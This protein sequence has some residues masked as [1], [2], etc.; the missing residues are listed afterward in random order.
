MIRLK[1]APGALQPSSR[2]I[3]PSP[4]VI[5]RIAGF[6]PADVIHNPFLTQKIF[7]PI[8]ADLFSSLPAKVYSTFQDALHGD[9]DDALHDELDEIKAAGTSENI[10]RL[11]PLVRA[12]L[13]FRQGN[14]E[15][16]S[17]AINPLIVGSQPEDEIALLSLIAKVDIELAIG[18]SR[19]GSKRAAAFKLAHDIILRKMPSLIDKIDIRTDNG[20][21]GSQVKLRNAISE[22][23]YS[24]A[25]F[26]REHE[27]I[28]FARDAVNVLRSCL[29]GTAAAI[30]SLEEDGPAWPILNSDLCRDGASRPSILSRIKAR[31]LAGIAHAQFPHNGNYWAVAAAGGVAGG[32]TYLAASAMQG[33]PDHVAQ[34]VGLGAGLALFAGKV[35]LG[36]ISQE[37]RQAGEAGFTDLKAKDTL[38]AGTGEIAKIAAGCAV[39]GGAQLIGPGTAIG[40]LTSSG[41]DVW[42]SLSDHIQANGF[43]N[44]S[45]KFW[46]EYAHSSV[47]G[48]S[49]NN[50]GAAY[51]RYFQYA[52]GPM[53]QDIIHKIEEILS[54]NRPLH[55]VM[56]MIAGASVAYNLVMMRSAGLRDELKGALGISVDLAEAAMLTGAFWLGV[57]IN[58]AFGVDSM[59]ASLMPA[60]ALVAYLRTMIQNGGRIKHF[61]AAALMGAFIIPSIYT[62]TGM[63]MMADRALF[64][65]KGNFDLAKIFSQAI[66]LQILQ[67]PIV[68]LHALIVGLSVREM[69]RSMIAESWRRHFVGYAG[70]LYF[71]W[72]TIWG[73]LWNG[74]MQFISHSWSEAT[75]KMMTGVISQRREL[76]KVMRMANLDISKGA[77]DLE[78]MVAGGGFRWPY[79]GFISGRSIAE[80]LPMLTA[81]VNATL[82]RDAPFQVF[83]NIGFFQRSI[84]RTLMDPKTPPECIEGFLKSLR[85]MISLGNRRRRHVHKNLIITAY[86]ARGGFHSKLIGAFFDENVRF[87][88]E[89]TLPDDPPLEGWRGRAATNYLKKYLVASDASPDG[90]LI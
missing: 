16:A 74:L 26:F 54:F 7:E 2:V 57:N 35:F 83:P 88:T 53:G 36:V 37:S 15:G 71:G 65:P 43:Q 33:S 23:L 64:D 58:L 62:G 19:V 84:L 80:A 44:G 31:I 75:Y 70:R 22:S 66:A 12:Q 3:L 28:A 49:M 51:A 24:F 42:N 18:D 72:P 61:M 8:H 11:E 82:K 5:G 79:W 4:R 17:R 46:Q 45:S 85:K 59:H 40:Y 1:L 56:S 29:N 69:S 30:R 13:L 6:E 63:D 73:T 50:G 52:R 20:S 21:D 86:A 34:A 47:F 60:V 25:I 78:N 10:L 67:S 14:L 90:L 68:I 89:F 48:S 76:L 38:I 81:F 55:S 77:R 39:F 41:A 87:R 32:V 27:Y 9:C